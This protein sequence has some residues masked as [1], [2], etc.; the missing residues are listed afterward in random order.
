MYYSAA[1]HVLWLLT[2]GR[3]IWHVR[4]YHQATGLRPFESYAGLR[5]ALQA[6][7]KA[8][9][10]RHWRTGE[11]QPNSTSRERRHVMQVTKR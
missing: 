11:E 1:T 7:D 10:R 2:Y 6:A 8:A 9:L 3:P 4:M 5:E